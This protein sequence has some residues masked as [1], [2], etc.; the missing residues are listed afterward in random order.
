MSGFVQFLINLLTQDEGISLDVWDS[1]LKFIHN[2]DWTTNLDPVI[3]S[4]DIVDGRVFLP[5]SA[6]MD[7]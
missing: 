7:D 1:A 2:Q 4:V 6:T 5:P 3:S